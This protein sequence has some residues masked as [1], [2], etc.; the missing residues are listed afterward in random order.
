MHR[1][2]SIGLVSLL[3]LPALLWVQPTAMAEDK[4]PPNRFKNLQV[5]AKDIPKKELK[6]IMTSFTK[7]LDVEC[8]FC[9]VKN[10]WSKD[11][12]D[13]KI[14]A[15]GMIQMVETLR[16]NAGTFL[17]EGTPPEKI[18]CWTCHRGSP[19]IEEQP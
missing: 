3:L 14:I 6:T 17:P 18:S 9:H 11:D 12:K 4:K 16:Q 15:R 7:Q 5:L 1:L 2:F 13:T 19:D 10:A 8:S